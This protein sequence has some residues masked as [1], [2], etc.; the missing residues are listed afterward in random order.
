M[1]Q[2]YSRLTSNSRLSELCKWTKVGLYIDGHV[3]YK[4]LL[5]TNTQQSRA[6]EH[7][8]KEND[9]GNHHPLR[10]WPDQP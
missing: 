1:V 6:K 7:I 2:V 9:L 8:L 4:S 5:K 3:Y 10:I